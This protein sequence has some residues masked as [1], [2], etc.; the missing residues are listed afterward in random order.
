LRPPA[1]SSAE[2]PREAGPDGFD[3]RTFKFRKDDLLALIYASG[4]TT[5]NFFG[6]LDDGTTFAG[7]DC[8]SATPVGGGHPSGATLS[9]PRRKTTFAEGHVDRP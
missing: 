4:E 1:P 6:Q 2:P 8:V 3:D 5:L 7:S 9:R